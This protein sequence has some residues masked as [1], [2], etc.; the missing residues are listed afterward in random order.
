MNVYLMDPQSNALMIKI[1]ERAV[2]MSEA[3]KRQQEKGLYEVM[4]A[5]LNAGNPPAIPMTTN[6]TLSEGENT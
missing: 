5:G 1:I 2:A 4:A 6:P 3:R